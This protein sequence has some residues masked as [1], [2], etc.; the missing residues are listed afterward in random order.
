MRTETRGKMCYFILKRQKKYLA[1]IE[2]RVGLS[3]KWNTWVGKYKHWRKEEM[4]KV[5]EK[6]VDIVGSI[7]RI[8]PIWFS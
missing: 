3:N 1:H 7:P 5:N 8:I 2:G 4:D 6:N